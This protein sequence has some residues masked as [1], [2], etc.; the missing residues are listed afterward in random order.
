MY[1]SEHGAHA[2]RAPYKAGH[3]GAAAVELH[4][5][6]QAPVDVRHLKPLE[7]IVHY[8]AHELYVVNAELA[9]VAPFLEHL[10]EEFLLVGVETFAHLFHQPDVAEKLGA[11]LR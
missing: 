2:E 1:V 7:R 9:L 11:Q 8:I 5:L 4:A 3:Y 6:A 10:V